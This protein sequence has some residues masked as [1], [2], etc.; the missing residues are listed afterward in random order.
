MGEALQAEGPVWAEQEEWL[1][2]GAGV[3]RAE[4]EGPGPGRTLGTREG[5]WISPKHSESNQG[6]KKC[7]LADMLCYHWS[8]SALGL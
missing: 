7:Y 8:K 4:V 5:A 3:Q 1:G 6:L 2:L